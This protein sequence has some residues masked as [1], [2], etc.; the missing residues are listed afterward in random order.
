M[1]RRTK[2]LFGKL[3]QRLYSLII[4]VKYRQSF[5]KINFS[6]KNHNK[7]AVIIHL[8][9]LDNWPLFARKLANLKG[10]S[11]DIFI[12]IPK[13]NTY[14]IKEIKKLYPN[15]NIIVVPNHGRDVLP[16]IK[17]AKKLDEAGYESVLK[18]HSKK[19][20]HREDG[21]EWL[22][23]MLNKLLPDSPIVMND[24]YDKL[25]NKNTGVIG[26]EGVYYPLTINFPANGTHLT[27]IIKKLYG[28]QAAH[29]YLQVKRSE[30]GFFGGTMFWVRLNAVRGLLDFPVRSFEAEARQI[31]GTFSHA[32]E[33]LFTI[34]PEIDKKVNYEISDAGVVERS[35]RS[36]N[37]PDWSEDHLK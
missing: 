10:H 18:F 15:A 8:F 24:V 36:T 6:N 32:L 25:K 19:S 37:I 21:Q 7:T 20:T 5:K 17:V 29:E 13:Q 23:D 3:L 4:T 9:Y 35:Y 34:V 26:P 1:Y 11:F 2:H 30:Y 27:R 33:R 22:A 12:T 28:N 31:D 16:F 14:F